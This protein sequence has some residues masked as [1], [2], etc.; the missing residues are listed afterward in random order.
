M[1][2]KYRG[3]LALVVVGLLA[4]ALIL[5]GSPL[6][7]TAQQQFE[8]VAS[9]LDNPRGLAF[10]PEGA[11][12]VAEAGR[13]GNECGIAG[14]E[15]PACY[16]PTGA[17]T[18]I[19]DSEQER[20]ATGLSS[21][22]APDGHNAFGPHDIS[23]QGRGGAYVTVGACFLLNNESCG[24]LVQVAASGQ[25]RSAGDIRAWEVANNPDGAHDGESNPY[26]VLAL[27]SER[28]VADAAGN[29]LLRVGANGEVSMLALFPARS[30]EWPAPGD[31]FPM[32]SVPT[33]IAIGPD[34]AYYVGELTGFPFPENGARIYRVL[35]GQA[36]ALYANGFTNIIDLAFDEDGSLLVLEIAAH[37]LM[38]G[39]PAGQLIRLNP[40]LSRETLIGVDAGLVSPTAVAI[41]DDGAIYIS[42]HG[43]DPGIGQVLRF[44]LEE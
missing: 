44:E 22:A 9:G 25:W 10:G 41:G 40:D 16:G 18:R 26:A 35:P 27:P 7:T 5:L 42:N 14:P 24:R 11:L 3:I 31:V 12:Y 15:G 34:G 13:G 43:Q 6:D 20:V 37:S 2:T 19:T 8:V 30:V 23:F 17:I 36:P 38:S 29:T 28:I 32:D 21:F 39:D 1:N 4:G 33:A